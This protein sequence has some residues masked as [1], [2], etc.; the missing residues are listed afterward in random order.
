MIKVIA[1]DM[2]GTLLGN[3]HQIA[4]ETAE[5]IREAQAAGIRFM[6]ATGRNYNGAM[7]ELNR[8]DLKCDYIL[9]SGAEIRN[10]EREVVKRYAMDY[11]TC[12]KIQN[13]LKDYPVFVTFMTDG[14]DYQLGTP[15]EVRE[16]VLRQMQIFF[17]DMSLEEIAKTEMYQRMQE[18]TVG[19]QNLAEMKRQGATVYKIFLSSARL[20]ALAEID[21]RLKQIKGIA[22]ASSFSTNLEITSEAAQKGPVLKEYIESLGYK[23][24]EVMVIGDSMNDYSML[25]MDFG[26]T[27]AVENAVPEIKA[28]VKYVTKSNEELG[29]AH[30][31]R[32]MLKK[33]EGKDVL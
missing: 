28:A 9:G 26:A 27:V 10:P 4:P 16:G 17:L 31:I 12:G 29:V 6:I 5:A 8:A 23:M 19:V 3:N 7:E 18:N 25:S 32:E 22:V 14:K 30:V 21:K 13:I 33:Q 11:D 2:D 20:E 24:E 1:S 15:E